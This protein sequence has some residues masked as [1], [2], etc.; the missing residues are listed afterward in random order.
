VLAES[1]RLQKALS[2]SFLRPFCVLSASLLYPFRVL[3]ASSLCLLLG[4][5]L[6]LLACAKPPV[7]TSVTAAPNPVGP[8]ARTQLTALAS[9]PMGETVTYHWYIVEPGSGTLL[10]S[11]GNPVIYEAGKLAGF[12][13]VALRV[14]DQHSRPA[15]DTLE[16][17]VANPCALP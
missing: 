11:V 7:I 8:N 4:V 15:D 6:L 1:P 3:S 2:A 13:H 9:S 10:Q 17:E 16:I 12:Y 5:L 14:L